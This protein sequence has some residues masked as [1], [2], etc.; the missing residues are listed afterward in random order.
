MLT[1]IFSIIGIK[2]VWEEIAPTFISLINQCLKEGLFPSWFKSARVISIHKG[3]NTG[4]IE[5]YRLISILLIMS[6][7]LEKC[8]SIRIYQYLK[9]QRI[10]IPT[11]F[12]FYQDC[13]IEQ[14]NIYLTSIITMA[15]GF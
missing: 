14:A 9:D 6:R 11:Q 12:G 5:N 3:G 15:L 13:T 4:D 10:F 1:D 8:F 2:T 7:I